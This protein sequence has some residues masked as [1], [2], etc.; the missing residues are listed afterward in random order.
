[1]DP[2]TGSLRDAILRRLRGWGRGRVFV[3]ADLLDLG[4]RN[5]VDVALHRLVADGTVRRLGRG[6]YDFPRHHPR[7]GSLKPSTDDLARAIAR[8][9]SSTVVHSGAVAANLFGLTT[10]VPARPV[11]LTDGRTRTVRV[12]GR[13]LRFQHASPKR[14]VGGDTPAGLALRALWHLGPDGIDSGVLRRLR[15]QLSDD[16]KRQLE[17]LQA[18]SPGWL[19]PAI[20]DVARAA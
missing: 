7:L 5:A 12:G 1:M 15:G 2:A 6:V 3:P 20:A 13:D 11:Y 4:S 14:L 10:Q 17:K 8:S 19:R 18:A 9:S 16:D